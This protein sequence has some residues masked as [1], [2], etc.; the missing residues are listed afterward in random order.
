MQYSCYTES[1]TFFLKIE[2]LAET[3]VSG[4]LFYDTPQR[5]FFFNH[6]GS[7]YEPTCHL[8]VKTILLGGKNFPDY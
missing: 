7:F 4:G 8:M 2:Y 1:G 5:Q 6:V 3:G